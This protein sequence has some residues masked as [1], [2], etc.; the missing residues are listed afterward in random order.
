MKISPHRLLDRA[1]E[2][3]QLA[4][5]FGC[6]H[7]LEDLIEGGRA[8]ADAHHLL[9]LAFQMV[10]RP[11]RAL[12]SIDRALQLNPRYV[13]A[14]IHRG[15]VLSELGRPAEAEEAFATAR[16][17]GGGDR[18]GVPSHH[19]SQLANLHA[20]L[21]EAY[22]EAG[23]LNQAIDQYEAA[24]RFGP[25]FHDLRYR[26]GRLLLDAGRSLE[27]REQLQQVVNARPGSPDVKSTFGLACYVAGD[28]ATAR[29]VWEDMLELNADDSRAI[30]YLAMLDRGA[31]T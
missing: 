16:E 14:H 8:F 25:E 12:E 23:A 22:V 13:E 27:A 21:G 9:G 30:T 28:A 4:D 5:Y 18:G 7:L 2:R 19:A 6:I 26:L 31:E 17:H 29:Q 15:I 24:L 11:E 3:F 10:G 1:K 20:S